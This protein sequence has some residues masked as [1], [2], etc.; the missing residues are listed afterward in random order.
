M[1]RPEL[2]DWLVAG[3]NEQIP[4]AFSFC[5]DRINGFVTPDD[6]NPY[7]FG[8]ET[9]GKYL[10]TRHGLHIVLDYGPESPIHKGRIVII[11]KHLGGWPDFTMPG[12]SAPMIQ[13][14]LPRQILDLNGTRSDLMDHL[15]LVRLDQP[16]KDNK[17]MFPPV[18]VALLRIVTLCES[19]S[20]IRPPRSDFL[21]RLSD[22]ITRLHLRAAT[23][24][25]HLFRYSDRE[26]R[27][28]RSFPIGEAPGNV[29][30]GIPHATEGVPE[31]LPDFLGGPLD[32]D[33]QPRLEIKLRVSDHAAWTRLSILVDGR[34][35]FIDVP[36]R[37]AQLPA[38]AFKWADIPQ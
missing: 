32:L 13:N 34:V 31:D 30:Q 14:D 18:G 35:H 38:S 5:H 9:L 28:S 3:W 1:T 19:P 15:V 27:V 29:I 16:V 12:N 6:D 33:P 21:L 10:Y 22:A 24:G 17:G 25:G 4:V 11:L 37:L 20:G 23:S 7:L 8:G 26:R 36:L 2:P